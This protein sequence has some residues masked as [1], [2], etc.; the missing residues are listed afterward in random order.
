MTQSI[1]RDVLSTKCPSCRK[2]SMFIHPTLNL[3]GML[4]MH[5]KC[6]SCG[7]DFMPE[8]GFYF[9]AMYFS[10]AINVALMV[11]FGVASEVLFHPDSVLMLLAFVLIP[12]VLVAPWNFRISRAIM[13]YVFGG[14][15]SRK[16]QIE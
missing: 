5:R 8:P 6:P 9:G 12:P 4:K 15:K 11:F 10:Y 16:N 2:E 14:I 13:L 1:I 3:T 7:Q